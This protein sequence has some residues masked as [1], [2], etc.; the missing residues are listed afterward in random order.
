MSNAPPDI[1]KPVTPCRRFDIPDIQ[2]FKPQLEKFDLSEEQ[3]IELFE[4]VCFIMKTFVD[5]GFGLDSIQNFLPIIP[6]NSSQSSPDQVQLPHQSE[7]RTRQ[8]AEEY[9]LVQGEESQ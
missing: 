5:I 2:K 8:G 3:Q 9:A 1:E 4:T 6:T 7:Q